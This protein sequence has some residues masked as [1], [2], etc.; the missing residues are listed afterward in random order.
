MWSPPSAFS[1]SPLMH[2]LECKRGR[3]LISITFL[4]TFLSNNSTINLKE[5]GRCTKKNLNKSIGPCVLPP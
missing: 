4:I 2:F 1:S 5:K 3:A